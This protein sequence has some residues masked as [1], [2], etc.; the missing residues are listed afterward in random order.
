M[1]FLTRMKA[2]QYR[3]RAT[4]E[5]KKEA[6]DILKHYHSLDEKASFA[7]AYQANKDQTTF[8]WARDFMQTVKVTKED[9]REVTD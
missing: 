8:Q 5:D 7:T 4:E 1:T 6:E 9:E 3:K 2:G